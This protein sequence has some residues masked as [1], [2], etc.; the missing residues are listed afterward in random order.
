MSARKLM[1]A[2]QG[3]AQV[4]RSLRTI[5]RRHLG[6]A[7]LLR[8]HTRLAVSGIPDRQMAR[9]MKRAKSRTVGLINRD[10]VKSP[11]GKSNEIMLI[12]V[13][14]Q[15]PE[16]AWAE[17][18]DDKYHSAY[19]DRTVYMRRELRAANLAY[20]FMLGNSLESAEAKGYEPVPFDRIEEIVEK[21]LPDSMKDFP[22]WKV[23]ATA[24][25]KHPYAAKLDTA[26]K[27][28]MKSAKARA[29]KIAA[30]DYGAVF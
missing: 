8:I 17:A 28:D 15:V 20:T 27:N 14:M 5:E 7:Q 22:A 2:I 1:L 21:Y 13:P 29:A 30:S 12:N 3:A 6:N 26:S 18:S 4:S 24:Y 25:G 11:S 19:M 23:E 10:S 16:P 9:I